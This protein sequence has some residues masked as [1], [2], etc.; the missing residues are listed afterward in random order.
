MKQADERDQEM[1]ALRQRLSMLCGAF[2]RINE[3]LD[4]DNVLQVVVD[5]AR[6]LT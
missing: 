2:Q 3:G 4:F 5:S 6:D 1:E